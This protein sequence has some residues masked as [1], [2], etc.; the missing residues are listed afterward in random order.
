MVAPDDVITALKALGYECATIAN[1]Y[2]VAT[3][4][5]NIITLN[6]EKHEDLSGADLLARIFPSAKP[7][8]D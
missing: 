6:L 3:R 5:D 7:T 8:E 4:G 1:T 2:T